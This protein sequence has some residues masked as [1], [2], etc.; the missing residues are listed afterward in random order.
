M[1]NA[2]RP[3]VNDSSSLVI[4]MVCALCCFGM[5]LEASDI[6]LAGQT[7][8]SDSFDRLDQALDGT[9]PEAVM[10]PGSVYRAHGS[11]GSAWQPVSILSN[12]VMLDSDVGLSAPIASSGSYVKPE[13]INISAR[14]HL[15]QLG[16]SGDEY[17]RGIGVGFYSSEDFRPNSFW[18]ARGLVLERSGRV[19]LVVD[20]GQDTGVGIGYDPALFGGGAFDPDAWHRLSYDINTAGGD[21]SDIRLDGS[22][23]GGLTTDVFTDTD[24]SY[25]GFWT[26]SLDQFRLSYV[27][28]F[29]VR[30]VPEPTTALI[31]VFAALLAWRRRRAVGGSH[32]GESCLIV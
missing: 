24:T 25:A 6:P 29:E 5:R 11:S 32:K 30:A 21:I 31:A 13:R 18:T 14:V 26:S 23:I 10:V 19:T 15:A 3:A 27:D 22:L 9:A 2:Q 4:V 8:L 1:Q 16:D 17:A 12:L 7:I 28:D 20:D